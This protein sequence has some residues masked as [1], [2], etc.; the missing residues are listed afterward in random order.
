MGLGQ[1]KTP[2]IGPVHPRKKKGNCCLFATPSIDF[3]I[4]VAYRFS[5]NGSSHNYLQLCPK[6]PGF[7]YDAEKNRYFPYKGPIPGSSSKPPV[8]PS[9]DAKQADG[10]CKSFKLRHELLQARE[11]CGDVISSFKKKLSF[12]AE[13]QK[14]HASRPVIWKYKETMKMANISLEHIV[15]DV[16]L[17]H[18]IVER[19]ILLSGGLIG[20]LCVF[21]VGKDREE[22][23]QTNVYEV[24]SVWPSKPNRIPRYKELLRY[25]GGSLGTLQSMTS[26]VSC[27]VSRKSSPWID[28]TMSKHFV[29]A[30]FHAIAQFNHTLWTA[31]CDPEG[32]RTGIGTSKG[33]ALLDIETKKLSWVLRCKSDVLSVQFDQSWGISFFVG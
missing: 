12:Q 11:L 24:D 18:G 8:L 23:D 2:D 10:L 3:G 14:R 6:L 1:S 22:F 30:G 27:I 31:D 26:D 16:M 21:Q 28:D 5:N 15:A 32:R 4:A 7:Y 19:D 25:L 9:S 29:C 33:V 13:Y 20:L 17:P